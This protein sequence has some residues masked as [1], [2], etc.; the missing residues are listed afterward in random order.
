MTKRYTPASTF[1]QAINA[2]EVPL[3]GSRFA[4]ANLTRLIA[5]MEDDDF[6]NRDWATFLLAQSGIDT[7]NVREALLRAAHTGEAVVRDEAVWGLALRDP[8]LAL[9][10]VQAALRE[11]TVYFP[12]LE[13][14]ELCADPSLI[15]DLIIW[16]Q[17]SGDNWMDGA[18]ERALAACE[19][20]EEGQAGD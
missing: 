11:Q 19:G 7:P 20:R 14:A 4:E 2:D 1:L 3:T 5:T 15:E 12:M 18:A 8:Q 10:L 17:P 9:P 13:A 6:S 16:A